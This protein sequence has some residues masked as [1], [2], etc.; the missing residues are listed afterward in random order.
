MELGNRKGTFKDSSLFA[1]GSDH[2][3]DGRMTVEHDESLTHV[4]RLLELMP[5]VKVVWVQES[6]KHTCIGMTI[7]SQETLACMVHMSFAANTLLTVGTD[8]PQRTCGVPADPEGIRYVL[9]INKET[10]SFEPPS[11]LQLLGIF[12]ARELKARNLLGAGESAQLQIAWHAK[13]I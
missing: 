5:G 12:L 3:S 11:Q 4:K 7:Q 13:V 10:D 1:R 6:P 8:V 9:R 2:T